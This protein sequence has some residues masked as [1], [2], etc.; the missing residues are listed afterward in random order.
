[1]AITVYIDLSAKLE[2]WT[3][4]SAIAMANDEICRVHLVPSK[5]KQ[6]SRQRI[7]ELYGSATVQYRL[8]AVLTHIVIQDLLPILDYIVIDK[9]YAGEKAEGTIKNILLDLIRLDRPTA[10][11]GMIRFQNVKGSRA[12]RTAKEVYDK[13]RQP[14]RVLKYREIARYLQK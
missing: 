3:Q 7:R 11:A 8:I 14:D 13:K 6:Q 12:D 2:Q 5:V 4:A 10:T 9:D 1:M